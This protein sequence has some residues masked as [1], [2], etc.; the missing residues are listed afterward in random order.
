MSMIELEFR[1]RVVLDAKER[2]ALYQ[3]IWSLRRSRM[4][5]L[6]LAKNIQ[7]TTLLSRPGFLKG[8][9][10]DARIQL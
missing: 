4:V 10:G 5:I 8:L 6:A 1:I 9:L 2:V 3:V 7:D